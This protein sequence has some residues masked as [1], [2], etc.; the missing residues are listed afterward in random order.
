MTS[1]LRTNLNVSRPVDVLAVVA[2]VP[3]RAEALRAQL[4]VEHSRHLDAVAGIVDVGAVGVVLQGV[5][6]H[7]VLLFL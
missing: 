1:N 5:I 4:P 6:E 3:R 2:P 7:R